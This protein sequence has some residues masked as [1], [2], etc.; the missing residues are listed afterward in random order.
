MPTEKMEAKMFDR[1]KFSEHFLKY[2]GGAKGCGFNA[3][4]L[5]HSYQETMAGVQW[6]YADRH[7]GW[8]LADRLARE[9]KLYA[10][11][12]FHHSHECA[13]HAFSYGGSFVCNT[14]G[15]NKLAKDWWAI[16]CYQDGNAW[17]CVGLDFEDL[18]SSDCYAFGDTRDAAIKNYGDLMVSR[19][20]TGAPDAD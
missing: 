4:I 19:E 17:C 6:D 1:L 12:N 5:G 16:K 9:G 2:S 13:G 18:Q 11:H 7:N 20:R 3:R 10:I 14:C 8:L 15:R